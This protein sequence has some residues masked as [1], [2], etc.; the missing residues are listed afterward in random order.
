MEIYNTGNKLKK[1]KCYLKA[2]PFFVKMKFD[3]DCFI[4][5]MVVEVEERTENIFLDEKKKKFRIAYNYS[6]TID[7][8]FYKN[9]TV[10]ISRC[11]YCG[12]F[13]ADF[14]TSRY[15]DNVSE[16]DMAVINERYYGE[17]EY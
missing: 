3:R 14:K 13:F 1:I 5:H 6:H 10:M 12:T 11:K 17:E 15:R 9:A 2:I 16:S 7:E 8:K 4:P